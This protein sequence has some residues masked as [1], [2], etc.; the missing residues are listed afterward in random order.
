[1]LDD[2]VGRLLEPVD[3]AERERRLRA[4]LAAH[5]ADELFTRL[6]AESERL[7]FVDAHASLRVAGALVQGACLAG[8]PSHLA[9][10]LM[11]TGDALR[12][13]GRY[14]ESV[15]RYDE[16]ATRF[17]ELDDEVGWSRTRTGWVWS[18]HHLG[19]AEEALPGA[20]RAREILARHGEWWR[21][22]AIDNNAGWVW[23]ELGRYDEALA[24]LDRA[25]RAYERIGPAAEARSARTKMNQAVV[26]TYR[27]DFRTALRLHQEAR[28]VLVQHG[29]TVTALQVDNNVALIYAQQ[30]HYTR[31]LRLSHDT[32]AALEKAGLETDAAIVALDMLECYLALN[33]DTE[34]LAWAEETIARFE[35]CGTPTEA[36]KARFYC[37][38]AHAKLGES[39]LA[40][41]LLEQSRRVFEE[42]GLT[43][44]AGIAALQ[45]A[46]LHVDAGDWSAAAQEAERA[47]LLF[48]E[49]G[50]VVRQ[51]QAAIVRARAL[52]GLD[53]SSEAADLARSALALTQEY[54]ILW[55]A[56]ECHHVLATVARVRQDEA[57]ALR[58][59]RAAVDSVERTQSHLS[60][61][62]RVN[63]LE[64]KLHVYHDAID[65]CL[66][67][68]R[69]GAAFEYLER[70]KSRALLDYLAGNPGVRIG[71]H[72]PAS[73]ELSDE[74]ARLREEHNWLYS[75]L[76]GYGLAQHGSAPPDDP[77]RLRAAV[78]DLERRIARMLERLHLSQPEGAEGASSR[79]SNRTIRA[80]LDDRTVLLE[81]YLRPDR[82]AVFVVS[83]ES[84]V[85]VPLTTTPGEVGRLLGRWQLNLDATA[86]AIGI[87]APLD[88]LERNARGILGALYQALI[89]PLEPHLV[90][91]ERIVVVPYGPTHA[92]PFHA[93]YDG[94]R[95][96]LERATVSV[97]PSSALFELCVGRPSSTSRRGLVVAHS[98]GGRLPHVLEEAAAVTALLSGESYQEEAATRAALVEA[99][100]RHGVLHLAAH[101]EARLDNPLFAHIR[102]ADGQ[103][104]TADVFNLDLDGALV[105]LSACESGRSAVTGGD[106]LIGL[107]RGFLHAGA[108]TLV[109]SLWR[110]E[111]RSTASLMRRFY[112]EL[113]EGRPK[114]SAL[115]EAQLALLDSGVAH[116]YFWAPFQLVGDSGA[117]WPAGREK[118]A[119][120][121]GA[122]RV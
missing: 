98:D 52:L 115:G 78:A 82:G 21:A 121:A 122:S 97:C 101:G 22:G 23:F 33:R 39:T 38:L 72:D 73:R 3:E 112:Q 69:A 53:R 92:V 35:R 90:G 5:T 99:A 32:F 116:P 84:L 13:L 95:Y 68:G 64:D 85:V 91:R 65:H 26:L 28:E 25:Q 31:A 111:D 34:A 94:R 120:V 8:R 10:G 49:R 80:S 113:V 47:G 109:Q 7:L 61:E 24:L 93:L 51:A 108:S 67:L 6:R 119:A 55:L 86:R 56:H 63:F 44:F 70:A 103:L 102:L 20:D 54:D 4:A 96:L 41:S 75:R 11:A 79:C 110:V 46:G 87:G 62:L 118:V 43:A 74:L 71:G 117:L 76:Y 106:E 9:L 2:V 18:M 16:A 14:A 60:T 105:T 81:L 77:E 42:A 59:Y 19:R 17:L 45:R 12:Y 48:A 83:A 104:S 66:G 89:E 27:G 88:G 57:R 107:S 58:E 30:G 40:L 36:A 37:A 100:P 29:D 50:L 1:M 114:G 15:Q